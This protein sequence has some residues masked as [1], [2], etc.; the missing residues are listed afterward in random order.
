[1][2]LLRSYLESNAI[3]PASDLEAAARHQHA[4]GGSFDTALLELGL[5]TAG[6]LDQHLGLACGMPTVPARLLETG[7]TRPWGHVPKALLDIGWVLPLA[8]EDGQLF[9]AVHPDLPDARLGQLYRQIRGFTPM[10][11]PECCLAKL[12]AERTG[13]IVAPRHAMLVLDVLDALRARESSGTTLVGVP[14]PAPGAPHNA[15][16]ATAPAAFTIPYAA[17]GPQLAVHA[18]GPAGPPPPLRAPPA[19]PPPA[20]DSLSATIVEPV[21]GDSVI[22]AAAESMTAAATISQPVPAGLDPAAGGTFPVVGRQDSAPLIAADSGTFA[23]AP[24]AASAAAPVP[25]DSAAAPVPKDTRPPTQAAAPVPKDTR[26]PTQAAA[27]VPKDTRPPTQAA[28]PVPKDTRAPAPTAAHS[29]ART[30]R[31]RCSSAP[32]L[33]TP[34]PRPARPP[35]PPRR[36]AAPPTSPPRPPRAT[37]RAPAACRRHAPPR[38]RSSR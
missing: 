19:I 4:Q 28:A 33:R 12:S 9:A 35:H 24:T 17:A 5:L 36:T 26:P 22:D 29:P 18:E 20:A 21:P 2:S 1:L 34:L 8:L 11:T 3:L 13:G 37:T 6:D 15:P 25:K 38:C 27:P 7:P 14:I 30:S 10:V 32:P 31:P 16:A 23:R